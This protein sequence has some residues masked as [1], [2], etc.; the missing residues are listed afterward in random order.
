MI[1]AATGIVKSID[2]TLLVECG[3]HLSLTV[4]WAKSLLKRMKFTKHRGTTKTGI[5]DKDFRMVKRQFLQDIIDMVQMEEIPFQ[6]IFNWDQTGLNLVP[7]SSWTMAEK[8][9]RHVEIKGLNDKRQ[10]TAVFCGTICGDF[11]PMQL[12]YCGKTPR[13]HSAYCFPEDWHFTHSSNHWSNES[14][15]LDYIH[16]I[17]VPYVDN[18]KDCLG[19][20]REK[21]ALAI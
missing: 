10:I 2:K 13:C 14:M 18:V 9:S 5:S 7:A 15:M 17:T 21:S 8:G 11:L 19:V 12:I 16:N 4:S 20:S 3:G 1:A 6:L